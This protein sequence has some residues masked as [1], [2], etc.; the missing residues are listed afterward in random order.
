MVELKSGSVASSSIL[1]MA[2][3]T[4]RSSVYHF[5]S[6]LIL[7]YFLTVLPMSCIMFEIKTWS[8][9]VDNG[10]LQA[11]KYKAI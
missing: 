1:T 11:A 8:C 10:A 6:C 9:K 2:V 5:C 3:S 7:L 4:S